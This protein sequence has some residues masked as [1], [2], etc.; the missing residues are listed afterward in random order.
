M[1]DNLVELE[2][3]LEK[4]P[5]AVERRRFG[6]RLSHSMEALRAAEHQIARLNAIL[7]LADLTEFGETG[8]QRE[9]IGELKE[10]A[11]GVADAL[12]TASTEGELRD[13]ISYYEGSLRAALAGADKSLRMHWN[14]VAADKF[15]PLQLLGDLLERIGVAADLGRRMQDCGKRGL[16]SN[17]GGPLPE[18]VARARALLSE[19]EALQQERAR[20][21]GAGDVGSFINAL[22]EHRA[23]LAMVTPDVRAW[24]TQ[25]EALERF[26]VAPR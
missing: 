6:D 8:T 23:N 12:E 11:F 2:G 16:A 3:L 1:A 21:I 20:T 17:S 10:E 13:A 15:R 18:I 24:L 26:S 4:L 7:D 25:N 19:L 22:A 5:E 14:S 9:V